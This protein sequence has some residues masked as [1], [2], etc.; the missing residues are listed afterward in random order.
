MQLLTKIPQHTDEKISI[1]LVLIGVIIVCALVISFISGL[2][3]WY[4]AGKINEGE[5]HASIARKI[6]DSERLRERYFGGISLRSTN[7]R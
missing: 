5:I 3:K 4:K 2:I 7:R 1:L 6:Q